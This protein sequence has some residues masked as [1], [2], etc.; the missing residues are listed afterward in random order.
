MARTISA[1][2]AFILTYFGFMLFKQF[3]YT[4]SNG[5]FAPCDVF[6]FAVFVFVWN[7]SI[8]PR[9]LRKQ[10]SMELFVEVSC[11]YFNDFIN[12]QPVF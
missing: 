6:L 2:L 10:K 5:L 7:H 4:N 12:E 11:G 9:W 8:Y 3:P 1:A